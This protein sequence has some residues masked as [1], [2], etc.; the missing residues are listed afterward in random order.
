MPIMIVI[1]L[2]IVTGTSK[3]FSLVFYLFILISVVFLN[4]FGIHKKCCENKIV[5]LFMDN[6]WLILL[7][8]EILN[9]WTTSTALQPYVII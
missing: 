9:I 7:F 4:L 1:P 8:F 3:A 5:R 2:N 6:L